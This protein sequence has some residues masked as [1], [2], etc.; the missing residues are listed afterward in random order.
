M[1]NKTDLIPLEQFEQICRLCLKEHDSIALLDVLDTELL[2]IFCSSL[3]IKVASFTF[4]ILNQ[5]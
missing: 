5:N 3:G 1:R 2:D 4:D